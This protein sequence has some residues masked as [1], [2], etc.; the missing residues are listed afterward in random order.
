VC[1]PFY[2]SVDLR[3]VLDEYMH[4]GVLIVNAP[5]NVIMDLRLTQ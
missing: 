4:G 3:A 5:E 1:I 2:F